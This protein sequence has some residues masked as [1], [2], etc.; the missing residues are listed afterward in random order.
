MSTDKQSEVSMTTQPEERP[1]KPDRP[2]HRCGSNEWYWP[3][4]YYIGIKQWICAVCHP[5]VKE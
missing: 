3:D 2:C 1:P 5:P 4:S